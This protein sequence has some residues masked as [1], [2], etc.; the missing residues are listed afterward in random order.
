MHT[1]PTA[2]KILHRCVTDILST[3]LCKLIHYSL[4]CHGPV[5]VSC[6]N[7]RLQVCSSRIRNGPYTYLLQPVKKLL[8]SF[9]GAL[10]PVDPSVSS[11]NQQLTFS[12]IAVFVYIRNYLLTVYK[13]S[14]HSQHLCELFCGGCITRV[15]RHWAVSGGEAWYSLWTELAG[16]WAFTR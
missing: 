14:A 4:C 9:C 8:C 5:T 3:Y 12:V 2:W 6:P 11:F 15:W 13:C 1:D 7:F 10:N 16:A